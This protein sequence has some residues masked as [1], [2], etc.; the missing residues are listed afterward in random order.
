MTDWIDAPAKS[1]EWAKTHSFGNIFH[2][3]VTS[4]GDVY[5]L[6]GVNIGKISATW[7]SET[8]GYPVFLVDLPEK[9]PMPENQD[10][11]NALG[12]EVRDYAF[13]SGTKRYSSKDREGGWFYQMQNVPDDKKRT[14]RVNSEKTLFYFRVKMGNAVVFTADAN[15][16]YDETSVYPS[17][18]GKKLVVLR[19]DR[20]EKVVEITLKNNSSGSATTASSEVV[21][22]HDNEANTSYDAGAVSL[23]PTLTSDPGGAISYLTGLL[24]DP[25]LLDGIVVVRVALV[26]Y[27]SSG[28][29]KTV[30]EKSSEESSVVLDSVETVEVF[31]GN[32]VSVSWGSSVSNTSSF[33]PEIAQTPPNN[34]IFSPCYRVWVKRGATKTRLEKTSFGSLSYERRTVFHLPAGAQSYDD[35]PTGKAI[36]GIKYYGRQYAKLTITDASS[37]AKDYK[38]YSFNGV[39]KDTT[40]T[41][42]CIFNPKTNQFEVMANEA[43]TII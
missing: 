16:G 26:G 14:V 37:G 23:G 39:V 24:R 2:G 31:V 11:L 20:R 34:D 29:V 28:N 4:T 22:T 32:E 15:Q 3:K 17:P 25:V 41:E 42:H 18:D 36:T 7:N 30:L 19:G 6:G 10:E 40:E 38:F 1:V 9:G 8:K 13:V 5:G 43:E 27:D 21:E 12:F 35:P 33:P